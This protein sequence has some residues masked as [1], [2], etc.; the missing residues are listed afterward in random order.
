MS[1]NW[2]RKNGRLVRV[3][4]DSVQIPESVTSARKRRTIK[5]ERYI[6]K[7]GEGL[8]ISIINWLNPKEMLRLRVLSKFVLSVVD[9]A[10]LKWYLSTNLFI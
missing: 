10:D 5:T 1:I 3:Q 6:D 2:S 9:S 8:M 4:N 7:L